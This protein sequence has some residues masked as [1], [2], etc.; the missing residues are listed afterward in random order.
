[1]VFDGCSRIWS[2]IGAVEVVRGGV[3]T[4][5]PVSMQIAKLV[6]R[7]VFVDARG[8]ER[9]VGLEEAAAVPFEDGRMVRKI[10]SYRGQKRAPVL[11]GDHRQPGGVRSHLECRWMTRVG[12]RPACGGVRVAAAAVGSG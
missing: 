8:V 4:G 10:P 11:V 2:R 7:V 5:M 3:V 1:M 9:D 12:L 6:C